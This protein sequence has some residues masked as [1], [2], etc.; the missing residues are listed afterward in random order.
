MAVQEETEK[1]KAK[2][3]AQEMKKMLDRLNSRLRDLEE[4][5]LSKNIAGLRHIYEMQKEI[6]GLRDEATFLE[7]K[8][9]PLPGRNACLTPPQ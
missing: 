2:E 7:L 1:T 9:I 8:V 3:N 6:A 4:F 5:M